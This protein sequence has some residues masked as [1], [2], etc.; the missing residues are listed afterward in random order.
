MTISDD[1]KI[2]VNIYFYFMEFNTVT[3]RPFY[4]NWSGFAPLRGQVRQAYTYENVCVSETTRPSY[5]PASQGQWCS[6]TIP[7]LLPDKTLHRAGI[8]IGIQEV[9]TY[10]VAFCYCHICFTLQSEQ[11]PSFKIHYNFI[12]SRN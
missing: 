9:R 6:M 4:V 7:K 11:H 8:T 2:H 3:P 5:T 1:K 12:Y 10:F